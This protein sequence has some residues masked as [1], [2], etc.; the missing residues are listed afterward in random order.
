MVGHVGNLLE[1]LSVVEVALRVG[2]VALSVGSVALS[3][4]M[5]ALL[6]RQGG[7]SMMDDLYIKVGMVG[8]VGNLLD[9]FSVVA[10][11]LSV[12]AEALSVG[13]SALM[14]RQ[15]GCPMMVDL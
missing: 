12:G 15:G 9:D 10:V 2:A 1:A 7:C 3:V 4:G 6:V 5:S 13:M 8:H 11:A 14:V